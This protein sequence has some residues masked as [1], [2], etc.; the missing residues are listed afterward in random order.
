MREKARK[1]RTKEETVLLDQRMKLLTVS[2]L[3]KQ[4]RLDFILM[5]ETKGMNDHFADEED[6]C[7]KRQEI[8]FLRVLERFVFKFRFRFKG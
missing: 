3:R 6:K 1:Q 7:L 5:Q 2:H 4:Q 8:E